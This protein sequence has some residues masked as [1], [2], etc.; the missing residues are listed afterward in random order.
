MYFLIVN[1]SPSVYFLKIEPTTT[2]L[3][4]TASTLQVRLVGGNNT[5][6]GRVEVFHDGSWGTVCD[7]NWNLEDANVVCRMLGYTGATGAICCARF[8]LGF[9]RPILL[10]DVQCSGAEGNLGEC[11]HRGFGV[12]DCTHFE[13]AGVIC[14]QHGIRNFITPSIFFHVEITN[15]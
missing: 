12:H 15:D 9:G 1:I 6:E 13:D 14:Y 11:E 7:D 3:S 4:T 8:G 5:A 2:A 10:D